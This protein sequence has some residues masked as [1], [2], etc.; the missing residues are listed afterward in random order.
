VKKDFK[1]RTRNIY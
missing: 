1:S